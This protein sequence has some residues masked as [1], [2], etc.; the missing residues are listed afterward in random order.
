M[1][2]YMTKP[3]YCINESSPQAVAGGCVCPSHDLLL[4]SNMVRGCTQ[5]VHEQPTF[6]FR[7]TVSNLSV[8]KIRVV[9]SL[10]PLQ[11]HPKCGMNQSVQP[12]DKW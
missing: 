5:C 11:W 1:L 4:V 7:V 2:S 9:H 12:N 10:A 3:D 6:V 8:H